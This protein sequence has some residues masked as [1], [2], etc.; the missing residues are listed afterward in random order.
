MSLADELRSKLNARRAARTEAA[1]D[2]FTHE[3]GLLVAGNPEAFLAALTERKA[4]GE[5][6]GLVEELVELADQWSRYGQ[7]GRAKWLTRSADA[8]QSQAT[9]LASLKQQLAEREEADNG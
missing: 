8:L 9:E 1:A 3:I 6:E 7:A 5:V 2:T 4:P